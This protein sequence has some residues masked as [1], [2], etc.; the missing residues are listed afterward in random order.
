MNFLRRLLGRSEESA[1]DKPVTLD[2]DA[3]REQLL[4]LEQAVDAL[5]A[6]MREQ[7]R[8]MSNPGWR[9]RVAE[10]DRVAGAATMLRKGTPTREG[11]LDIS[12][13]VRPLFNGP[14]PEGLSDLI[15]LQEP[16]LAAAKALQELLPGEAD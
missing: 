3:R 4:T 2:L 11:L 1:P 5:T 8:L 12:F 10:Y 14:A 9:G 13:E 7:E 15:A 6:R 16:M